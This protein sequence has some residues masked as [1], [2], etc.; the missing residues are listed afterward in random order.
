MTDDQIYEYLKSRAQ[1]SP[2]TDL[3]DGISRAVAGTPQHQHSWVPSLLPMAAAAGL[4]AAVLVTALV[5]G[6]DPEVGPDATPSPSV[7]TS[8][9]ASPEASVSAVETPAPSTQAKPGDLAD[10]GAQATIPAQDQSGAWGTIHVERLPDRGGLREFAA[11]D[12]DE[13]NPDPTTLYFVNDPDMFYL[14]LTVEYQVDREPDPRAFGSDDWQLVA[15]TETIAPMDDKLFTMPANYASPAIAIVDDTFSGTL[16]F[17]V[18]RRLEEVELRLAYQPA[19]HNQATWT[20]LVRRPGTAPET[21]V[22]APPEPIAYVERHGLPMTVAESEEAELLFTAPDSCTNPVAGYTVSYPDDWYTNTEIGPWP[23][24]SWF[25][26]TFFDVEDPEVVPDEVAITIHY[27]PDSG[28]FVMV[29]VAVAGG[30][31]EVGARPAARAEYVGV[32]GGFIDIGSF[33]YEYKVWMDGQEPQEGETGDT[34]LASASWAIDED[35][36]AY[37]LATAVLDRIMASLTFDE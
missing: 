25:S 31:V 6:E 13:A 12:L 28:P 29:S 37:R 3:A 32:G 26:P 9:E 24:C 1:G 35:Q 10:A 20:A 36:A 4:A 16:V 19:S 18:P 15:G 34:L 5:I 33:L 2:P 17:A 21:F 7:E 8:V 23:A 27:R 30:P 11:V 14:E 22:M